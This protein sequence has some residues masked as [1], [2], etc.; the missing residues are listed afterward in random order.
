[1]KSCG[2][3]WQLTNVSE[4][5]IA[6]IFRVGEYAKQEASVKHSASKTLLHVALLVGGDLDCFSGQAPSFSEIM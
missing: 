2:V 3:N 4:Q 1:M 5:Y 6:F